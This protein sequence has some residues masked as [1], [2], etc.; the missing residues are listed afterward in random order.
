MRTLAHTRRMSRIYDDANDRVQMLDAN[1]RAQMKSEYKRGE[2]RKETEERGGAHNHPGRRSS[3]SPFSF[4]VRSS[5]F[6]PA[7]RAKIGTAGFEP[8]TP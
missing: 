1:D 2:R 7:V 5:L 4:L 3:V 8:A 6:W